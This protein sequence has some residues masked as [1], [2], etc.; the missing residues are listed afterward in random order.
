MGVHELPNCPPSRTAPAAL[1]T[2]ARATG[3][4]A[5]QICQSIQHHAS[6][7]GDK[8]NVVGNAHVVRASR[9]SPEIDAHGRRQRVI[10]D[11]ARQR[12]AEHPTP[13]QA[14]R[15]A[16]V[17]LLRQAG[18]AASVSKFAGIVLMNDHAVASGEVR[19]LIAN[20]T[21]IS[22]V[23]AGLSVIVAASPF[24]LMLIGLSMSIV[25]RT[26]VL[27]GISG[28]TGE[29]RADKRRSGMQKR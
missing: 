10:D 1:G 19:L 7:D 24:A 4:P 16:A 2:G 22:A 18:W 17:T 3:L 5:A 27:V 20:M 6:P 29:L 25:L 9:W 21:V 11:F 28:R 8:Q 26:L 15:H 13:G 14:R 12:L 23:S